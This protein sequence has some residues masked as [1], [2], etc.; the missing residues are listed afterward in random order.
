V[1][2]GSTTKPPGTACGDMDSLGDCDAGDTC[3]STGECQPNLLDATHVCRPDKG[4]C[5]VAEACDGSH[6]GCP[7]DAFEPEGTPC[8]ALDACTPDQCD[9]AGTCQPTHAD[10]PT[11]TTTTLPGGRGSACAAIVGLAHAR[12]LIDDVLAGALCDG[13]TVPSKLDRALRARLTR[14]GAKLDLAIAS[15]GKKRVRLLK[16]VRAAI[17]AVGKKAGA[18]EKSRKPSKRISSSCAGR[19]GDL[20]SAIGRD[21]S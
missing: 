8:G 3:G 15:D 20:V 7:D 16:K 2:V 18:A 14:A 10:C 21:L 17:A 5:D 19:F 9:G 11:T 13:E 4:A 6:P 12:C 1:C